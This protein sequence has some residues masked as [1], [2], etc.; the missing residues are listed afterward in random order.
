MS[1][2]GW[3]LEMKKKIYVLDTSVLI[4]DPDAL[5]KFKGNELVIP[6]AV[7]K[8]ID[9]LKKDHDPDSGRGK[10]AREVARTLDRLGSYQ[11]ISEGAKTSAGTSIRI[12]TQ[13]KAIDDLASNADNRIVGTAIKLKE[14]TD[15]QVIL[16]STDGNMRNI[17]RAYKIRAENYP[18]YRGDE[19]DLPKTELLKER[20]LPD[21][22]R[23]SA[24]NKANG[25]GLNREVSR[26][27]YI[28]GISLIVL[29]IYLISSIQ[30]N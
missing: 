21:Y 18:F 8:E 3:L 22:Q 20:R 23:V 10:A 28:L 24:Y 26:R 9:G 13:Y 19:I 6:T 27:G 16:V 30:L 2:K 12:C 29:L 14:E 7:I 15:S 4:E 17:T 25:N 1:A 11:D 5:Y